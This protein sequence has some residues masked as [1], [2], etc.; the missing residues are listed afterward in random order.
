MR[1][2]SPYNYAFDNPVRFVDP[3]GMAPDDLIVTGVAVQAFK[4][5]VYKGSGGFYNANIDASGK[6][7][8]VSTGLDKIGDGTFSMTPL[9]RGLILD[10]QRIINQRTEA[11]RKWVCDPL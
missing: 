11:A 9:G 1:R 10:L 6:V 3:D 4:D 7:S 5:E 8:L 2:Y